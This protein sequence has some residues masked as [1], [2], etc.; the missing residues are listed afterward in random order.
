VTAPPG[1]APPA[2]I[3]HAVI[4]D[5]DG[6]LIDSGAHHRASW[7]AMLG[8]LGMAAP[9]QFWRLTIGR[10]AV[11]AVPLLVGRA[12]TPAEA[13]QLA[14]RKHEHYVRFSQAGLP[15]VAGV[16]TFLEDLVRRDVPRA[17]ATSARRDDTTRH[18]GSLGLARYFDVVIAAD[19]VVNGKPN[20]EVYLRAAQG[21]ARPPDRCVVFEDA[22]VGVTAA[23]R[24]G[25]RVIGV[26]TAYPPEE[27]LAAGAER[28]IANFEECAWPP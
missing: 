9:P 14:R 12:M 22:V 23:R 20:P 5:M 17:V 19:D 8:E 15:A 1:P 4:F 7:V 21:L 26:A 28:V 10:P 2:P 6:V 27:L 3:P 13:R 16:A 25:M 18:L 24:A 11:E